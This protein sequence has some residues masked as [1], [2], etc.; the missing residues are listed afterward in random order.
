MSKHLATAEQRNLQA[1]QRNQSSAATEAGCAG[2]AS[3]IAV[4]HECATRGKFRKLSRV[5]RT[6]NGRENC[7]H[8]RAA[9][10]NLAGRFSQ[11]RTRGICYP[12]DAYQS[13]MVHR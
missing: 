6:K 10:D 7:A 1:K 8:K 2:A 5:Q 13:T 12:R 4:Q 3:A 9:N 11:R